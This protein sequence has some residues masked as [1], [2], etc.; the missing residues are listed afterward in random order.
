MAEND[1]A[2]EKRKEPI[3]DD[4]D[5]DDRWLY[6]SSNVGSGSL[7][8]RSVRSV[9]A[10]QSVGK[11]DC[12]PSSTSPPTSPLPH[13]MS[14]ADP[15]ISMRSSSMR[16]SASFTLPVRERE[17]L[18]DN[19]FGAGKDD[20]DPKA[21]LLGSSDLVLESRS[22]FP[23]TRRSSFVRPMPDGKHRLVGGNDD[24]SGMAFNLLD[25][26]NDN[27]VVETLA[28][29]TIDDR[30]SDA[31]KSDLKGD[32]KASNLEE[33]VKSTKKKKKKSLSVAWNDEFTWHTIEDETTTDNRESRPSLAPMSPSLTSGAKIDTSNGDRRR[34]RPHR[35]RSVSMPSLNFDLAPT[36]SG[37][38]ASAYPSNTATVHH[39]HRSALRGEGMT[40][41][42]VAAA[43]M[44]HSK[45]ERALVA[46]QHSCNNDEGIIRRCNSSND[47][48]V[49]QGRKEGD[50][51]LC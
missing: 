23:C 20:G 31:G 29:L 9:R 48:V 40:A 32:S 34:S 45:T 6:T 21:D 27:S 50:E 33:N 28:T 4:S 11:D 17:M 14:T 16:R 3:F 22:P 44:V 42:T 30:E 5:A 18:K 43:A 12:G 1:H 24:A 13:T 46:S 49:M 19:E 36:S 41:A 39:V 37:A 38:T 26:K 47:I 35:T 10:T 7:H 25:S 51:E 15:S 2:Y 8:V